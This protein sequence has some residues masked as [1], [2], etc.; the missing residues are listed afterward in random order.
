MIYTIMQPVG[1][2]SYPDVDPAKC[3]ADPIDF[4]GVDLSM[5][6]PRKYLSHEPSLASIRMEI[7]GLLTAGSGREAPISIVRLDDRERSKRARIHTTLI[8]RLKPNRAIKARLC[9]RGDRIAG[10]VMP[11]ASAP[12]ADRS[13]V[14]ILVSHAAL[15]GFPIVMRDI[16]QAFLQSTT[17]L[18]SGKFIAIPPACIRIKE[19]AW[20]GEIL[21]TASKENGENKYGLLRHK[22]LYGSSDAP[23]RW[24]ITIATMMRKYGYFPHRTDICLF[25]RRDPETKAVICLILLHVGDLLM[26][27]TRGEIDRFRK[28]LAEFEHGPV[29]EATE[30]NSL[31][32]CGLTIKKS[33]NSY[34]ITQDEYIGNILPVQRSELFSDQKHQ[35][36]QN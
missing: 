9:L 27:G 24:Y 11:F 21:Q 15:W 5:I 30:R 18:D 32:Y 23:L 20:K 12:T 8:A 25:S 34:G 26:T 10:T 16:S 28:L 7:F 1:I 17:L 14:K 35:W 31:M 33:R 22:P 29:E 4:E 3:I 19:N 13:L 36:R 6:P 2:P